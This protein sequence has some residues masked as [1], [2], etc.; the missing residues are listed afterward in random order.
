LDQEWI[1]SVIGRPAPPP[2]PAP[3]R[4]TPEAVLNEE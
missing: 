1:D 2:R 4:E 3:E